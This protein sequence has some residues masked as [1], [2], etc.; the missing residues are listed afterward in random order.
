M[1]ARAEDTE[2]IEVAEGV[3]MT[4]AQARENAHAERMRLVGRVGVNLQRAM[5]SGRSQQEEVAEYKALAKHGDAGLMQ[6][7]RNRGLD[8]DGE[9]AALKSEMRKERGFWSWLFGD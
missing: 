8:G 2:E 7:L 9:L 1:G 6:F 5:N 4:R 3:W